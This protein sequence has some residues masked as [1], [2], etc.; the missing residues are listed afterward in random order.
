MQ[1]FGAE[2]L[3]IDFGG[4]DPYVFSAD[5]PHVAQSSSTAAAAGVT[6][7]VASPEGTTQSAG[8]SSTLNPGALQKFAGQRRVSLFDNL[9]E[10]LAVSQTR[11]DSLLKTMESDLQCI[12]NSYEQSSPLSQ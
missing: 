10:T 2:N 11:R 12:R 9:E 1:E 4:T 7:R 8:S 3:Q 6:Q 5:A